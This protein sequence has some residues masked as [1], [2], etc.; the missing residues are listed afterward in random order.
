VDSWSQP[1]DVCPF[2]LANLTAYNTSSSWTIVVET[3]A[4]RLLKELSNVQI[5]LLQSTLGVHHR[6]LDKVA[7]APGALQL[8]VEFD[9]D[10]ASGSNQTGNGTHIYVIENDEYVFADYDGGSLEL[11]HDFPFQGGDATLSLTVDA[12]E[13]PPVA[14]HD[15]AAVESCDNMTPEGLVLD[16][17]RSLSADP[18]DDIVLEIW[19]IDGTPCGHGCVVPLGSHAV[20]IEAHDARGAVHRSEDHWVDVEPGPAC[21]CAGL[22][23]PCEDHGDCCDN[24][25]YSPTLE[26]CVI[27]TG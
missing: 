3:A 19:W 16:Q 26:I 15:L 10:T 6:G 23:E 4:G 24:S 12:I 2:F 21:T 20:A 25:A 18:D 11:A 1:A 8:R 14:D 22:G 27:P 17:S 5:D 9:V 13:H 7:F